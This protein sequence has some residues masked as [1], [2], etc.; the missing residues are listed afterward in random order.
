M[1]EGRTVTD[2]VGEIRGRDWGLLKEQLSKAFM[3]RSYSNRYK[4]RVLPGN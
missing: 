2:G 4:L 3:D 1:R